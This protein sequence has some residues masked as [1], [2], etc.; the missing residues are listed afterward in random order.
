MSD[1]QGDVLAVELDPSFHP[2]P[3][4]A[5]LHPHPQIG[6]PD[7]ADLPAVLGPLGHHVGQAVVQGLDDLEGPLLVGH[8][9]A[10]QAGRLALG[11]QADR[12][13]RGAGALALGGEVPRHRDAL[14]VL[15]VQQHVGSLARRP[16]RP[17]GQRSDR[18]LDPE[19]GRLIPRLRGEA[20]D[21]GGLGGPGGPAQVGR[22][23]DL[24]LRLQQVEPAQQLLRA[25][26][27]EGPGA[28]DERIDERLP[29]GLDQRDVATAGARIDEE[30]VPAVG[31][32][33]AELLARE[34]PLPDADLHPD[35]PVG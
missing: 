4:L 12:H 3:V 10:E 16:H 5:A 32:D 13:E 29:A 2:E 24:D 27:G 31:G 7:A 25:F 18:D 14:A 30:D 26:R 21:D 9:E 8:V 28:E 19:P 20:E 11:Q 15:L 23:L 22:Q 17:A 33:L 35:A 6:A 1:D 34:Q